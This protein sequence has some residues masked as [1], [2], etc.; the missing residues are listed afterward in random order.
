MRFRILFTGEGVTPGPA[1][2][3]RAFIGHSSPSWM[4][5]GSSWWAKPMVLQLRHQPRRPPAG[6]SR[7]WTGHSATILR[8]TWKFCFRISHSVYSHPR[9]YCEYSTAYLFRHVEA[10]VICITTTPANISILI[11]Q[12]QFDTSSLDHRRCNNIPPNVQLQ[13]P[14]R[15]M[16]GL[17]P[18]SSRSGAV[19]RSRAPS[20]LGEPGELFFFVLDRSPRG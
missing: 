10:G 17:R 11:Y 20:N 2:R 4:P 16:A 18:G 7:A 12:T 1:T 19:R 8:E 3:L 5:L 6:P 9:T 13:Q 14:E 15:P